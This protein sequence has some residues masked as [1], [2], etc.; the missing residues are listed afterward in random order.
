MPISHLMHHQYNHCLPVSGHMFWHQSGM[1]TRRLSLRD[2]SISSELILS[3][4]I[5]ESI[6]RTTDCRM[7]Q[8]RRPSSTVYKT[9]HVAV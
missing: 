5:A 1:Y 3:K 8:P 7:F 9:E 6:N 2:R 4:Y